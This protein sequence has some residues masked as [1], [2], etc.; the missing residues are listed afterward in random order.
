LWFSVQF[1]Q[2]RFEGTGDPG[3]VREAAERRSASDSMNGAAKSEQRL[4]ARRLIALA[5]LRQRLPQ[6]F[7][8]NPHFSLRPAISGDSRCV[9]WQ[10]RRN[11]RRTLNHRGIRCDGCQHRLHFVD[12][13]ARIASRLAEAKVRARLSRRFGHAVLV[14]IGEHDDRKIFGAL[15]RAEELQHFDAAD[16]RQHQVEQHQVRP[17]CFQL[18]NTSAAVRNRFRRE[19]LGLQFRA[20]DHP[21]ARVIFDNQDFLHDKFGQRV[22]RPA[23]KFAD[24]Y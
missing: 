6:L 16:L 14:S 18:F 24:A 23:R 9:H 10:E 2:Q 8:A 1:V 20:V 13:I 7:D 11:G 17:I 19:T 21:R 5:E 22:M 4:S 12:E 3:E 15:L